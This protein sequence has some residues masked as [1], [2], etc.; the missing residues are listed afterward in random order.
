M[1]K[2]V[3]SI[4]ILSLFV[5]TVE[6]MGRKANPTAYADYIDFGQTVV[7]AEIQKEIDDFNEMQERKTEQERLML[8]TEE[9]KQDAKEAEGVDGVNLN[10]IS[11]LYDIVE[12]E[13]YLVGLDPKIAKTLIDTESG[14]RN[15]A[16]NGNRNGSYDS[17]LAQLNNKGEPL[18]HYYGKNIT[19]ADGRTVKVNLVNYK[20]DPRLNVAMGL[21]RYKSYMDELGN[22]FSAYACYNIGPAIKKILKNHKNSDAVTVITAVRRAGYGQGANNLKNNFL[23]KYKKWTGGTFYR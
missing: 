1:K 17:G 18:E 4:V 2:L 5:L 23:V 10:E 22:P 16:H 21:R 12:Q 14:F 7:N 8:L 3:T 6:Y 20:R 9:Q 11:N 13:S 15:F 19:L